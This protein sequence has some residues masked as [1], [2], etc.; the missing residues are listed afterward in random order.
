MAKRLSLILSFVVAL[1]LFAVLPALAEMIVDTAWVRR[2]NG[3]SNLIDYA[4][5]I[6][7]DGCGNVYVTGTSYGSGT[8]ED[9][10]TVK[11][12]SLGNQLWVKRYNGPGNSYYDGAYDIAID[13]SNNVYVIGESWGSGTY[14]DYATVKYDSLGNQLWVQRYNGPEDST[15][16]AQAIAV[17]GSGNV[18]VTGTSYGSGTYYDYATI[19][20]DAN[21]N[22]LWVQRYNG[23]GNYSDVTNAIVAD[24]SDNVYVTGFSW[25]SGTAYD[26]ATVKYDPSGN[27]VWVQRY[28]GPPGN[29]YDEAY[30]IAVDGSNNVYVTG[31]SEGSGTKYDYA[32]LKYDSLGNQLWIQRYNGPENSYN[33]AWAIAVNG[34]GNV[35]VTGLSY[36]SGTYGDYATV[37]Y[38]K[39]GNQLWVKRYNGP[40]DST[41]WAHAI[42]VD[43]S[44]N[45]Y[46]TGGSQG[47]GTAYDYATIKYDTLGNQLWVKRYDGPGDS[48]DNAYAIAVDGSNNV[49]VTGYSE[50]SGTAGDYVT[51]KYIQTNAMRGD[52]DNDGVVQIA[53]IMYLIN[54]VFYGGNPPI[55]FL[56]VGN[57][58]CD[59]VV[60]I[61]DIVYLINYV[62][63]SGEEP[64]CQ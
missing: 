61:G 46:V 64:N 21:G 49:Y 33:G 11:Y 5:A 40:G 54:Y 25:G 27:Q 24:G 35:Y 10:A 59:D 31:G 45:V 18:Y 50:G 36:G 16:W 47:S 19:K 12:D 6:A 48:T 26:Y 8:Y 14:E 44:N 55:P 2:Y 56:E 23:P 15:D 30:A 53:D 60:D 42:A 39:L 13:G 63:Y 4:Q 41:D 22:Q 17:D 34:L 62:F 51:I 37:K 32:T 7:L 38:D 43:G 28:N 3:P 1:I 20:Y 57:C 52:A 9:Y 58:N 29:Y